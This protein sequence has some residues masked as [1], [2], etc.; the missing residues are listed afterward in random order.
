VIETRRAVTN[1]Y[2]VA[3][4]LVRFQRRCNSL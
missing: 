2:R 4:L 3:C 1:A